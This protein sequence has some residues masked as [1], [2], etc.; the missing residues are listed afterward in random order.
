MRAF[1]IRLATSSVGLARRSSES[2]WK[3]ASKSAM[4]SMS[5]SGPNERRTSGSAL[6]NIITRSGYQMA[7]SLTKSHSPPRSPRRS[8]YSVASCAMRSSSLRR[9]D[10]MNQ[11]WVSDRYRLWSGSSMVTSERTRWRRPA[12]WRAMW[13]SIRD[14]R[15]GLGSLMN[16]RLSL[17]MALM[18]AWRVTE[19][20][21]SKPSG[22]I[23]RKGSFSR[24]QANWACTQSSSAQRRVSTR[25]SSSSG[26]SVTTSRVMRRLHRQLATRC[27]VRADRKRKPRRRRRHPFDL[28]IRHDYFPGGSAS[29]IAQRQFAS[30]QGPCHRCFA[31]RDR[32][33]P[34]PRGH[35]HRHVFSR[36]RCRTE[37]ST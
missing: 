23:H 7:T 12:R 33:V 16:S 27:I 5:D 34:L 17:S 31:A 20:N 13:S 21:G 24:S 35:D 1:A 28:N 2:A 14:P 9:L 18:S 3:Y 29:Q 36:L 22:V 11:R 8:T 25:A 4:T 6:P 26:D 37:V 32:A 15:S 30:G 19:K 10:P